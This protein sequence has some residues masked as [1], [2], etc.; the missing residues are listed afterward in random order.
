MLG[1]CFS[2][3][4]VPFIFIIIWGQKKLLS[5]LMLY[6]VS[7]VFACMVLAFVC[8]PFYFLFSK[9]FITSAVAVTCDKITHDGNNKRWRLDA[10]VSNI[11]MRLRA[12]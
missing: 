6:C 4:S 5:D 8:V 9:V 3:M 7:T 12:A 2:S 11:V 10:R 1:P